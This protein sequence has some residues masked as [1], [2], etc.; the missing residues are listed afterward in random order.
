MHM[1]RTHIVH[2]EL[3]HAESDQLITTR[4]MLPDEE[5]VMP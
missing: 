5:G 2:L 4:R 3:H 1:F